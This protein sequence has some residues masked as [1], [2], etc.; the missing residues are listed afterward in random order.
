[1]NTTMRRRKKMLLS[2]AW[3]GHGRKHGIANSIAIPSVLEFDAAVY[4]QIML[5]GHFFPCAGMQTSCFSK[6][7]FAPPATCFDQ[8]RLLLAASWLP[9]HFS[10]HAPHSPVETML[11]FANAWHIEAMKALDPDAN[12]DLS[13]IV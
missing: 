5:F 3:R 9:Q 7:T 13:T 6:C 10:M 8:S 2:C 1:M 12:R 4:L 11:T